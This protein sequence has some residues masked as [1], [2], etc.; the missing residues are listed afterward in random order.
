MIG[1]YHIMGR[2]IPPYMAGYIDVT[3]S[4]KHKSVDCSYKGAV[5]FCHPENPGLINNLEINYVN[6][7]QRLGQKDSIAD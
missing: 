2:G 7:K 3:S 6:Y 5:V 1:P 4:A